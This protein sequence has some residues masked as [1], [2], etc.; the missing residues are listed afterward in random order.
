MNLKVGDIVQ[1]SKGKIGIVCD[2]NNVI[3]DKTVIVRLG[4]KSYP[5]VHSNLRVVASAILTLILPTNKD[6]LE[7]LVTFLDNNQIYFHL[8]PLNN[9]QNVSKIRDKDS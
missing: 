9:T 3:D 6:K 7:R 5:I 2:I 1:T 8:E 4:G